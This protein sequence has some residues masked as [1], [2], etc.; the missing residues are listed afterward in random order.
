MPDKLNK[1]LVAWYAFVL[2]LALASSAAMGTL[3]ILAIIWLWR[4]INA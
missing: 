1:F 4:Q 3:V 2:L